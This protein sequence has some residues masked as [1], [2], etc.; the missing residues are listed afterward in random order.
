MTNNF[1]LERPNRENGT[2][3]SEF[4]FVP[5]IFQWD[6]PKKRLPFTSQQNFRE[7]VVNN[8]CHNSPNGKESGNLCLWNL[9]S[10]KILLVESAI[11]GYGIR[12][13]L[14]ESGILLNP[15]SKFHWQ[16]LECSTWNPEST[17]WN[18]EFKTVLDSFTWVDILKSKFGSGK[19]KGYRDW[20]DWLDFVTVL[21]AS[22]NPMRAT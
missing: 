1:H 8:P 17:A 5:R 15:E 20:R 16:I 11:L 3:F 12:N 2:T 6:K 9:E 4:L 10:R 13:Q 22:H 7:F 18:P 19:D 14:N 21:S